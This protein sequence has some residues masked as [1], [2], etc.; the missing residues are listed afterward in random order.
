VY[1][2]WCVFKTK[3]CG[4][5][6]AGKKSEHFVYKYN[7][8]CSKKVEVVYVCLKKSERE[9]EIKSRSK[10]VIILRL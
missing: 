2:L 6:D 9:K 1:T 7:Y 8:I 4:T 10:A 5:C 3:Q